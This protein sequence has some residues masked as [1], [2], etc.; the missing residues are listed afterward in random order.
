MRYLLLLIYIFLSTSNGHDYVKDGIKIDHPVLKM[1]AS[2]SRIG[3]G[4][5]KIMN[6]SKSEIKLIKIIAGIAKKQEIHEIILE[7]NIYKMRPLKNGLTIKPKQEIIFKPKSYHFM[8]FDIIKAHK[9]NELLKA[10]LVFNNNLEIPIEFK[11]IIQSKN[12]THKH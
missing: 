6:N 2:D 1:N 5:M 9:E 3:A 10:N 8:F 7:N 11:V 4:Y 12:N